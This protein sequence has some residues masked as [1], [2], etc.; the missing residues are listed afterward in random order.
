MEKALDV[1]HARG[2]AILEALCACLSKVLLAG[3]FGARLLPQVAGPVRRMLSS[4][5][6]P[7]RRLGCEL[8][9]R[10]AQDPAVERADLRADAAAALFGAL[11]D[12][13][14]SV[15][16]AAARGLRA[17]AGSDGGLA[18]VAGPDLAR[19]CR[20]EGAASIRLRGL[21]L[22]VDIA[23]L[24]ESAAHSIAALGALEALATR[25]RGREEDELGWLGA[26]EVAMDLARGNPRGA[27]VVIGPLSQQICGGTT[28]G[29]GA[30]YLGAL[31]EVA[32]SAAEL[33]GGGWDAAAAAAGV[34]PNLIEDILGLFGREIAAGEKE[35]AFC[36]TSGFGATVAGAELLLG[37]PAGEPIIEAIARAALR[38]ATDVP[39]RLTALHALAA[40]AG[41]ERVAHE[42]RVDL[43]DGV[44]G[45]TA[46]DHLR[47]AVFDAAAGDESPSTPAEVLHGLASRPFTEARVAAYRFV[48]ALA[49]R[50]W[51]AQEVLGHTGL[52]TD[53]LNHARPDSAREVRLPPPPPPPPPVSSL[54][55][56][57]RI[58]F[59]YCL[60]SR[61][62]SLLCTAR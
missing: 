28:G 12:P 39:T 53:L 51:G 13:C 37:N 44:L 57:G 46:E 10:L 55:P 9:G 15:A 48:S 59:A 42:G 50:P 31:A 52:L 32:A 60:S 4:P 30:R 34:N 40:I 54:L 14:T 16:A 19:L 29:L 26:V 38:R 62:A 58:S 43:A 11:K 61:P 25:L 3:E 1:A 2:P 21:Q 41:A 6:S 33:P 5:P 36:A 20:S 7:V 27:S 18:L 23:A 45:E 35:E 8:L 49:A 17:T 47:R 24:S 22:A 56:P